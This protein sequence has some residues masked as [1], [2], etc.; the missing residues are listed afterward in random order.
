VSIPMPEMNTVELAEGN[1][2]EKS[3]NGL[4]GEP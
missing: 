2:T 4:H 3:R 1:G